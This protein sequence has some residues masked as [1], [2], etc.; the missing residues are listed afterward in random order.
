MEGKKRGKKREGR[1]EKM[2]G[3]EGRDGERSME[4]EA[5]EER[6]R[7]VSTAGRL[8]AITGSEWELNECY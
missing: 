6:G 5:K 3:R 2:R 4:R 1:R 7:S 8:Q